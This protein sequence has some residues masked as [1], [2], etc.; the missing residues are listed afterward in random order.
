M[1]QRNYFN[2][3]SV[4]IDKE[5]NLIEAQTTLSKFKNTIESGCLT[6]TYDNR[7]VAKVDVSK[8]YF[9]FDFANFSKS[10]LSEIINYFTPEKYTL[11]VKGGIQEIRLI[12]DELYIDN[13]KYKK[14]ICIINST[15]KSRALSMN[16]GLVKMNKSYNYNKSYIILTS[17]T[18]KHYVSSLPDKIKDFSD[19]L[20]NFNIEIDYHIKTIEDLKTKNV[21]ILKLAKHMLYNEDGKVI[22]SMELKL[23]ALGTTLYRNGHSSDWKILYNIT[24]SK[25]IGDLSINSKEIFDAYIEL[26]KDKDCSIIARESRRILD[27]L[28]KV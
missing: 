4:S 19:N 15:D 9:N 7:V 8:I 24:S 17:F 25:I 13:E 10:I 23:K 21:D 26:F 2:Q 18:N 16:V 14:M 28:E 12:G 27:A 1:R 20:I 6:T 11:N 22:K 3:M 5:F